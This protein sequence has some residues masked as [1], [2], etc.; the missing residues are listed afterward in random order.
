MVEHEGDVNVTA[1]AGISGMELQGAYGLSEHTYLFGGFMSGSDDREEEFDRSRHTYFEFGSGR[2]YRP[3]RNLLLEGSGGFGFGSGQGT[4]TYTIGGSTTEIHGKGRYMKPFLQGNIAL[5]TRVL[6][7]GFANRFS[8][9][10]FG[11]ISQSTDGSE[12]IED[13]STPLFLEPSIYARL[14]WD[15]IRFNIH[16]GGTQPISGDPDFDYNSLN[17]SLGLSF[18]FN[19]R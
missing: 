12:V 13:P 6:D 8:L 17:V 1:R 19:S 2:H 18:T 10:R 11:E 7:I 3:A 15:R 5:Q 4:S 16:I 9:I 14:G